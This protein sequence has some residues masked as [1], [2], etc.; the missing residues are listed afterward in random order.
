M[1]RVAIVDALLDENDRVKS[2]AGNVGGEYRLRDHTHHQTESQKSNRCRGG[3]EGNHHPPTRATNVSGMISMLK[4]ARL[5]VANT[6][7]I[8]L[9]AVTCGPSPSI[10]LIR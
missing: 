7:L 6:A 4:E 3:P 5:E 10:E 2:A 1:Q 9:T 8:T